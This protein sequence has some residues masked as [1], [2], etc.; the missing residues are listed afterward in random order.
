MESLPAL[1]ALSALIFLAL[2]FTFWANALIFLSLMQ[3]RIKKEFWTFHPLEIAIAATSSVSFSYGIVISD[4]RLL[5]SV[6]FTISTLAYLFY[7]IR[8]VLSLS[9]RREHS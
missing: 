8:R 6:T 1:A 5:T 3:R 4:S 9:E 7:M 2:K